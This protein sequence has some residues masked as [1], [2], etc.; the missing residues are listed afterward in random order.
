MVRCTTGNEFLMNFNGYS[1][2]PGNTPMS[3]MLYLQPPVGTVYQFSLIF[4]L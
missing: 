4:M 3:R 2:I 1:S